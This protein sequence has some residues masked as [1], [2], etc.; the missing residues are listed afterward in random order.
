MMFGKSYLVGM[1][2]GAMTCCTQSIAGEIFEPT[3]TFIVETRSALGV[4]PEDVILNNGF[5]YVLGVN[6]AGA[7]T[8]EMRD[9]KSLDLLR[10][11][12]VAGTI[13]DI[14]ADP[15]TG[16]VFAI[17]RSGRSTQFHVMDAKLNPRGKVAINPLVGYPNLSVSP[18]GLVAVSGIRSSYS[19]G[20]FAAVDVSDSA[21]PIVRDDYFAPNA[22]AGVMNG[23]LDADYGAIF[24]NASW[25]SRLAA[26]AVG[27]SY[28]M[29][30][31]SVETASGS[32]SEPYAVSAVLE[33]HACRR[34]LPTSFLVADMTRSVLSL[35][36][37]DEAFQSLD[38]LSVV[39]FN[40][41]RSGG[42]STRL[43]GT[44]MRE[45]TGLISASC[46]QSVIL[47]GS[48]NSIQVAQFA[49]NKDMASLERVG[50]IRLPSIATALAVDQSA[51]YAVAVSAQNRAIMRLSNQTTEAPVTRVIGNADIREL[52]R[53]LTEIGIPVGSI[54]GI[55]G[56]RTER[57]IE[58]AER[59]FGIEIDTQNDLTGSI[60]R[61]KNVNK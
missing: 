47:L 35:V 17:G 45:P 21:N 29:S 59:K 9:G 39:E 50:T 53:T 34:G 3:P 57:A 60:E 54:D 13:E 6:A 55:V 1:T 7:S 58:L 12:S 31:F 43:A 33:R 14:A 37:F 40:L 48:T 30:E 10:T 25:D 36:D 5:A 38:M 24:L 61:L 41:T 18:T 56:A 52:Q 28:V 32:Y 8:L 23:W 42:S 27:K 26:I 19:D 16:S 2:I 46:D 11:V 49:R 20:F 44:S 15:N 4:L 22:R 51:S